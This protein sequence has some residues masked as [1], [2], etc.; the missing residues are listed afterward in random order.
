MW[1]FEVWKIRGGE[2]GPRAGLD[3]RRGFG[4]ERIDRV[5]RWFN[6]VGGE[7]GREMRGIEVL[8]C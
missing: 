7:N 1:G 8:R 2:E 3:E 6:G 5:D 4:D